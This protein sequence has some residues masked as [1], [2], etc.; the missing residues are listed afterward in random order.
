MK[1]AGAA[2]NEGLSP[3]GGPGSE[4]PSHAGTPGANAIKQ[5]TLKGELIYL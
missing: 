2:I 1:A 4:N 5:G 3:G